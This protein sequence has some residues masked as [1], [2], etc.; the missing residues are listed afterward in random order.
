MSDSVD[1]ELP[2][3]FPA[4]HDTSALLAQHDLACG[5]SV[6]DLLEQVA[7]G[8][9][10][11]H[12]EHQRQCLHCRA[13]LA[14]FSR[15]WAPVHDAAA[16]PPPTPA[17]LGGAVLNQI[18]RLVQ[19]IWYTLEVTDGGQI[20]IAAR[21]VA[22]LAR[23]AARRVPGV[24]VALGRSTGGT[25]SRMVERATLGHRHPHAAVGVLGRTAV[26]D[27]AVAVTYGDQIDAVARSVQATVIRELREH[28]GLERV[29]VNVTV[30]D[31]L[32]DDP[33]HQ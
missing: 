11:T 18:R 30:D 15:V 28:V 7:D 24:R 6:D 33:E 29:T 5:S 16:T 23:D 13:A 27:L 4:G 31:V 20:Q 1:P 12:T 10:D 3:A 2:G 25:L 21:I 17:E 19:D 32:S 8:R 22:T 14:E 26:V 9:V